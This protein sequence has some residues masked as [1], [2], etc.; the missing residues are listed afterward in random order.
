MAT[1]IIL[2]EEMKDIMKVI[3]SLKESNLMI[4]GVSES[5]ENKAREQKVEFLDMLLGTLGA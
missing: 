2:K 5:I 4:K 1:L 3:K